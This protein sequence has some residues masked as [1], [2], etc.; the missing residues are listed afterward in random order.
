MHHAQPVSEAAGYAWVYC[1]CASE[2][3]TAEEARERAS[4]TSRGAGDD[5]E[6]GRAD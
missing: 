2:V 3:C 4:Y 5:E 1:V 6:I